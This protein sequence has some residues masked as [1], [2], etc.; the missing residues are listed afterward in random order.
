MQRKVPYFT[1]YTF[2]LMLSSPLRLVIPS[3][4]FFSGCTTKILHSSL[5][6]PTRATCR[7]HLKLIHLIITT[8]SGIEYNS[9]SFFPFL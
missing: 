6:G 2:S 9:L 5:I 3:G 4:L 8:V 1:S 7:D